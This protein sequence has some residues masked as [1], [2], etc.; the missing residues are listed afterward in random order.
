M[1]S[2][3]FMDE[4]SPLIVVHFCAKGNGKRELDKNY[5]KKI[6]NK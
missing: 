6:K 5:S 3:L 4:G 1:F 2:G